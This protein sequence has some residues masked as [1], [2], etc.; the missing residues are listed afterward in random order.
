MDIIKEVVKKDNGIYQYIVRTQTYASSMAHLI[1]LLVFAQQYFP[2]LHP[3]D[4]NVVHYG[5]EYYKGTFGI[6]WESSKE[7]RKDVW[8][9]R[10][11]LEVTL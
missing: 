11:R 5:G 3:R 8:V 10:K 9:E 7:P 2:D 1:Q 6:E 4:V